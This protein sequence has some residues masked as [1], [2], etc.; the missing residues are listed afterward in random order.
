MSSGIEWR[1]RIGNKLTAV[2]VRSDDRHPQMWRIHHGG[3]ISD[4]VNLSRAK[5]AAIGVARP[6]GLGPC[7]VVRWDSRGIVVAVS[8]MRQTDEAATQLAGDANPA[9]AAA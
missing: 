4:M 7:E 2:V 3:K 9:L 1:L 6:R 8:P 5:D